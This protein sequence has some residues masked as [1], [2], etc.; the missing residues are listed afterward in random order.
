MSTARLVANVMV[1]ALA[2]GGSATATA[3]T[4]A[5]ARPVIILC[6]GQHQARPHQVV[7]SCADAN[8]GVTKLH[9]R[10]WG[11]RRAIGHG[12]GFANTCVPNCARGR[13]VD[14]RVRVVARRVMRTP[15]GF[16]YTRLRGHAFRRPPADLPR[17]AI[18][19]L[20]RFGPDLK[21]GH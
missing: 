6:G 12:V 4:A 15:A 13:F 3:S 14:L 1:I 8:S 20:S 11:A 21:S 5:A 2:L 17:T 19:R 9:W 18:F 7:L 16:R 10:R